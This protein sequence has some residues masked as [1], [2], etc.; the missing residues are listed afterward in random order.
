MCDRCIRGCDEIRNNNVLGRRGKGYG[1]GIAFDLNVPMGN[2]TCISCGECM[3]SCPTGALTN[4][5]VVETVLPHGEPIE[6][7]ELKHLPYFEKVSGTFLE[8]NKNAVVRRHFK[9]G[10]IVCREGEYGST[11]FYILEGKA[12]VFLS[13]TI[14]HVKTSGGKTGFVSKLASLLAGPRT[15]IAAKARTISPH[16]SDRRAGGS[17][18]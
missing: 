1:A 16:N 9:K 5:T 4:R 2:S 7:E 10:E 12:H 17:A 18:V 3:V 8:L 14:A 11:A 13:T 15:T 6:A